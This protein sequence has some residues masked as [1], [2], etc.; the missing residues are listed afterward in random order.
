MHTVI[1]TINVIVIVIIIVT[2]V[3][4]VTVIVVMKTEYSLNNIRANV[5]FYTS[6]VPKS[7]GQ[8][9]W[10]PRMIAS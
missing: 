6:I 4:I 1:V 9:I 3:I 7:H 8:D 5:I 2:V 10:L